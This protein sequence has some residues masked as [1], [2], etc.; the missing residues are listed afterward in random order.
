MPTIE[1]VSEAVAEGRVK[2]LFEE[3]KAVMKVP[4]VP[5]IFRLMAHSPDYLETSWQRARTTL[6]TDTKLDVRTKRMLSL[7]VSAT[8]NDIYMIQENTTRLKQMGVTDP[9]IAELMTVVDVTNGLNK[10]V[11]GFQIEP[12]T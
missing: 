4:Q 2:K 9:E 11:K 10:V 5:M 1:P 7:A 6:L 8:N 12:G 3:I